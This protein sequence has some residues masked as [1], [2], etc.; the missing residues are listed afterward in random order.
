MR[1]VGVMGGT[2]DPPHAAHLALAQCAL[3][4]L[5]LDELLWLPAGQPWQKAGVSAATHRAA[6]VDRALHSAHE[7]RF[8]LERCELER[9]GPSF[10]VDTLLNLRARPA[11]TR[12]EWFLV[13][14][15]DQYQRLH[16]WHRWAELL[17]LATLAVAVRPLDAT[18]DRL[19]PPPA[20][21]EH[22][23][24]LV[25]LH[26]PANRLSS[27]EIRARCA[28]GDDVSPWVCGENVRYIEQ[29]QLYRHG[30]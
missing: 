24:R 28:R 30:H 12:C 22:A 11:Y 2:F 21:A 9:D 18:P 5:E 20:L 26:M 16:T 15:Q 1:R 6:M 19:E 10:M 8:R 3:S 25:P 23:H 29:N 7:P 17:D 27:S 4:E 13:M 14:G